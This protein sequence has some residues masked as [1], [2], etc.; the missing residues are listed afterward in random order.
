MQRLSPNR[1]RSHRISHRTN[2]RRNSRKAGDQGSYG[3]LVAEFLFPGLQFS[4]FCLLMHHG[5]R[6]TTGDCLSCFVGDLRGDTII[7]ASTPRKILFVTPPYHC[8]IAEIAGRWIPLNFVYLA[9]AARQTGLDVEIYDAMSKDHGYPEIE[10][11]FR[12][13]CADYVASSA[14]TA[15]I[16]DAVRTLE[17]AKRI[18]PATVTILGGVHATFMYDEVLKSS[19]AIDYIIVGEGE[20]TLRQL[21]TVL[22]SGG[23]PASVPGVVF[24]KGNGIVTTPKRRFMENIDDLPAAWDLVD[25]KDYPYF[26][27][28]DSRMGAIW[29]SRGC[30]QDCI[31]CSQQKFWKKSWRGRDPL[32]VADEIEYLYT[33]YQVNVFLLTDEYPTKDKDRWEAFLEAVIAKAIPVYLLMETRAQDIVRDR[34]IIGKYRKAGIVYIS[35]G[36]EATGRATPDS[37]G[38][39]IPSDEAKQA[40][41]LIHEHGIVSEASFMLGFPDETA[42]SVKRT[43]QLVQHYN[44]DNANFLAVTPWP[45][46]DIY[47]DV[48]EQI[49]DRD[50]SKYNLVDPIIEP[51]NMSML[52]L[53]VA[54]V[55]CYRKF[56]M[57]KIID[58]MTMKDDFKRAYLMR[59][60][61]LFMGSSFVFRKMGAGMLGKI[62]LKVEG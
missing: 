16:N 54:I 56:Y 33:T 62:R 29:T 3:N 46:S 13:S 28:P 52:Q 23:D 8:G 20:I 50:Y 53:E 30:D 38:K 58:V 60:T 40:L 14:V 44:P 31:F 59:F 41:D 48:K 45:Y 19:P 5:Q 49:R 7:S 42:A 12:E 10:Q 11:R 35:I 17:L 9:G 15:T 47:G 1:S 61:K 24:R 36:I 39:E 26:F 21:L 2:S 51:K 22:E 34:D 43:F 57:G 37:I 4:R 27:I 25:W 55:D 18:K 6:Q 32:K